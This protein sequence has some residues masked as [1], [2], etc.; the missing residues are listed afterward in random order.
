M[1]GNIENVTGLVNGTLDQVDQW[2]GI[3][4]FYVVF[5]FSKD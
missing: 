4:I 1:H 5:L 2:I 3:L